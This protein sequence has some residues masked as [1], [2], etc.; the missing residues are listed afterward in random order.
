M[1][2]RLD[3]R[4]SGFFRLSKEQQKLGRQTGTATHEAE[5]KV[6]DSSPDISSREG[7]KFMS[8]GKV[9]PDLL[10]SKLE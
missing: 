6:I 4:M 7:T 8:A 1:E 10:K 3:S 2:D 9:E 5:V